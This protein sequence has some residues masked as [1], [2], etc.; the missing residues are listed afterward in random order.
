LSRGEAEGQLKR[1][2]GVI[3]SLRLNFRLTNPVS[4][5]LMSED[6]DKNK[7]KIFVSELSTFSI[8]KM[9]FYLYN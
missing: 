8:H 4:N 3:Q 6:E 1:R 5:E 2:R 9:F 7:N